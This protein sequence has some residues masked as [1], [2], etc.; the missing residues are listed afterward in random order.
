MKNKFK[1]TLIGL[2]I[3]ISHSCDSENALDC[4]QTAG[5]II[6]K[7]IE[8]AFFSKIVAQEEIILIL[9][10]GDQQKVIVE[11][12]KNLL[13][14]VKVYVEN[15][16]LILKNENHC[17]YVRDYELTKIYVTAPDL[18]ELRCATNR[19]IKS[20]GTLTYPHLTVLSENWNSD[21]LASGDVELTLDNQKTTFIANGTSIFRISGKT[22]QLHLNFAAND[23]R[24]EGD[25]FIA[26]Q[27]QVTH[28]S[29][30]DIIVNPQNSLKGILYSVG[31]LISKNH[32]EIIEVEE[33]FKGK[34]IIEK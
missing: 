33:R 31:N 27:V 14:D 15:N 3:V 11:T 12:G 21:Y 17:N 13:N 16:Q 29:S 6:Q 25:D 24:F 20:E 4:F 9:K 10:Q 8:V 2:C 32:P 18:T 1:M 19:Y 22:Q 5:T 30:N 7:E 34:L 28:K 23:C 26:N